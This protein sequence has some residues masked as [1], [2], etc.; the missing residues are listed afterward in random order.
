METFV[1]YLLAT[2]ILIGGILF[3]TSNKMVHCIFYCF[4][5]FIALAGIF[6]LLDAPF[7]AA[8]QV[9]IYGGAVTVLILFVVM[10]T[11]TDVHGSLRA[12]QS[13]MGL[14]VVAF[15]GSVLAFAMQVTKWPISKKLIQAGPDMMS[16][17]AKEL[18]K[19]Y[20]FPFELA[21]VLLLA[22]LVGA[23]YLAREKE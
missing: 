13:S 4:C 20:F 5:M 17:F 19:N 11:V 8:A 16:R 10:L 7:I 1:F 2:I 15:F 18:F 6:L 22:A 23:I 9:F 14:L 21:G 12:S 3:M